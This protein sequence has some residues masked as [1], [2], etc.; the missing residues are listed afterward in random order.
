L[1]EPDFVEIPV[2]IT[3]GTLF[4]NPDS[5]PFLRSQLFD[6]LIIT[7]YHFS[8]KLS[9]PSFSENNPFI[10]GRPV[11]SPISASFHFLKINKERRYR[12]L[13]PDYAIGCK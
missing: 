2:Q 10:L 11:R 9:T 4:S 8:L 6:W 7:D 1:R 12:P 13:N 3:D 5:Q